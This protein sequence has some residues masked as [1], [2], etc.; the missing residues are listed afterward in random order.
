MFDERGVVEATI[1]E[2]FNGLDKSALEEACTDDAIE[3]GAE[4]VEIV[5]YE[6]KIVSVSFLQMVKILK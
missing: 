1:P 4:E 6:G 2:K 5:D 3:C